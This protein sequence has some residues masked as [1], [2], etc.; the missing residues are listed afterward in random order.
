MPSDESESLEWWCFLK[1]VAATWQKRRGLDVLVPLVRQ[2][3]H[4]KFAL[5][6]FLLCEPDAILKDMLIVGQPTAGWR[7]AA[8][9]C[10]PTTGIPALTSMT[11]QT[12]DPLP[13]IYRKPLTGFAVFPSVKLCSSSASVS[14]S[15]VKTKSKRILGTS[16]ASTWQMFTVDGAKLLRFGQSDVLLSTPP[17]VSWAA[18]TF[19]NKGWRWNF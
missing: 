10:S 17:P 4:V 6:Q 14:V 15:S 3:G 5:L 11:I 9:I 2:L 8:D 18:P 1:L 7:K 19:L 13:D 12:K 16:K